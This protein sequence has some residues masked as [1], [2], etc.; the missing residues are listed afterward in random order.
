MN[1]GNIVKN[2]PRG[3]NL[4]INTKCAICGTQNNAKIKYTATLDEKTFSSEIFSARRLPDRRHYQWVVCNLCGLYR[5]DPIY[6]VDLFDLYKES[7]FE[8]SAELHGLNN[9]YKKILR[10]TNMDFNNKSILELG[11]GTGFFLMEAEKL[12]FTSFLEIEPSISSK[13]KADVKLQQYFI[14]ELLKPGLVKND[15]RDVIVAFHVLDHLPDPK[16]SL[17]ILKNI[18]KP[19]GQLILA[20]HNVKSFSALLL[21]NKSPIFDVEHTYLFSKVSIR[22]LLESTGFKNIKVKHYKNSYSIAYLIHLMP[23]PKKLKVFLLNSSFVNL[24]R[25]IKLKVPLGN[26]YAIASK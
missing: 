21:K 6:N 5:S 24:F 19:E 11:G 20:V 13:A 3:G 8:Y 16:E 23:M 22:M 14:S 12:G 10:K 26:I 7:S 1:Y 17:N 9:S 2:F 15:S 4:F 18:L 25:R